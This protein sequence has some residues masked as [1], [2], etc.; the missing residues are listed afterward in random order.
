[1]RKADENLAVG[2][3]VYLENDMHIPYVARLQEIFTYTFAPKEVYFT[4]RW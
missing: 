1:M 4:A 2:Q 3:D